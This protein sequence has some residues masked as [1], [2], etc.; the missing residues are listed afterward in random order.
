MDKQLFP[1]RKIEFARSLR[2]ESTTGEHR[3]WWHLSNR[4]L[5][6]FKFRHQSAIGPYIADF[7]CMELK[8]IVEID[9]PSHDGRLA[10]DQNRSAFL[11]RRGFRV[12]R[13]AAEE[14]F[15]NLIGVVEAILALALERKR[16]L[17]SRCA[18]EAPSPRAQDRSKL[19][20]RG[21]SL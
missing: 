3:L 6:G 12:E 17:E 16:E 8:L 21:L 20:A 14:V 13:F 18:R 7:A 9:G 19:R 10:Y 1:R 15:E 4:Q 5:A 11:A 2:R